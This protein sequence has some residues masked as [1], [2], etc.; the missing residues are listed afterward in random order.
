M[1]V[2]E[3][4]V[5]KLSDVATRVSEWVAENPKL[6]QTILTIIG[7]IGVFLATLGP[8]LILV[9]SLITSFVS[10]FDAHAIYLAQIW[11]FKYDNLL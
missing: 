11:L 8:L 10:C 6:T 7:G 4:L 5:Q 2:L 9:G 3:P 1:P